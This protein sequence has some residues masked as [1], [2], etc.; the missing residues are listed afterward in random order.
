MSFVSFTKNE[1]YYNTKMCKYYKIGCKKKNCN[2][3]H[4]IEDL[5]ITKC[6]FGDK[7]FRKDCRFYHPND[8]IPTQDE[9]YKRQNE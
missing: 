5:K 2:F 9:L 6:I 7:C 4:R 1:Y 8:P 3:A